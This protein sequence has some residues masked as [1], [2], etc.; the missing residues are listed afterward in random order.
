[1]DTYYPNFL[2]SIP[3]KNT[4]LFQKTTNSWRLFS[5]KIYSLNF[6]DEIKLLKNDFPHIEFVTIKRE[7][8]INAKHIDINNFINFS[9]QNNFKNFAIINADILINH[10]DTSKW[11]NFLIRSKN[12]DLVISNRIN[13][14]DDNINDVTDQK[15]YFWGFDFFLIQNQYHHYIPK[16]NFALGDVA[17]DYFLP[18]DAILS[19]RKV[20]LENSINLLHKEHPY[21]WDSEKWQNNLIYLTNQYKKLLF[22]SNFSNDFHNFIE[23]ILNNK[24][25]NYFL[26]KVLNIILSKFIYINVEI[27]NYNNFMNVQKFIQ[28]MYEI[29]DKG[30]IFDGK[31][32]NVLYEIKSF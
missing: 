21:S 26:I 15:R 12:Y 29:I 16:T 19:G 32:K 22:K 31:F 14:Q 8:N 7:N 23:I 9:I 28:E 3:P 25:S 17:W 10:N 2:T 5:N 18:I 27:H 6:E 30:T 24:I 13:Y 11:N 20:L 1:M 4:K